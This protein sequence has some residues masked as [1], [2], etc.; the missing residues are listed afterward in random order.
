MKICTPKT[1][2]R[3]FLKDFFSFIKHKLSK[4]KIIQNEENNRFIDDSLYQTYLKL[5]LSNKE[6]SIRS[7]AISLQISK[8][9]SETLTKKIKNDLNKNNL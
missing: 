1:S 7:R 5:Y 2:K 3:L 8:Y 4:R 9:R 6:S